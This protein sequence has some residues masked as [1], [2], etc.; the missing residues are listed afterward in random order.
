MPAMCWE[1]LR[2]F[3]QGFLGSNNV[4]NTIPSYFTTIINNHNKLN[5]IYQP[6][7]TVQQYLE[8]FTNYRKQTAGLTVGMRN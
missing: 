5:D 1:L 3:L 2:E 6:L 7:D 4:S 8:H